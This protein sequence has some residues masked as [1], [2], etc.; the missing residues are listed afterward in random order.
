[1]NFNAIQLSLRT[2]IKLYL[3]RAREIEAYL[4][5][6]PYEWGKFQSE[7]NL[8]VNS[9]FREIME[10]ER[11]NLSLGC[12]EKVHKL[13][14]IFI[15]RI[16]IIFKRG[17]YG[18][19]S[20]DKPFGYAGDFKIVDDIYQNNPSTTGFERLFD[21]YFQMSAISVAVRNRKEDFKRILVD[22]INRKQRPLRIMNLACGSCRELKELSS[23]GALSDKKVIF[24]C[25]DREKRALV[26][27]QTLL[28]KQQKF[29]FIQKNALRMAAARDANCLIDKKYDFIYVTGLFDYLNYEV[30][31]LLV[32]NLKKLLNKNGALAV[33]DVRDRYSNPSLHYMEWAGDW[34]LIYR[35]DEEFR[36][37]FIEAGFKE[38]SLKVQYEQQGIM[39]YIIAFNNE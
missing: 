29:N 16:K 35:K 3:K 1:M 9:I 38:K 22:F 30:S 14:R 34:N 19:W 7:F 36:R 27:A 17:M 15:E 8:E 37:I 32:K 4:I 6:R 23:S 13:K 31:L 21:N 33:S 28:G 18:V 10:F 11:V 20:I 5:K 39:Q 25:Y 26:F 12:G 24:D 2:K